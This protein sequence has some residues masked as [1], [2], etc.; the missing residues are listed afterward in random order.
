LRYRPFHTGLP[1]GCDQFGY[2]YQAEAIATGRLFVEHTSRPFFRPLLER[3]ASQ[4]PNVRDYAWMIAPHAYHYTARGDKIINQYPPGVAAVL[5]VVPWGQRKIAYPA[6][7]ALSMVALLALVW[8]ERGWALAGRGS[9]ILCLALIMELMHPFAFEY[10]GVGSV[11]P[12][13]ALL[14]AAGWLVRSRPAWSLALVSISIVFRIVN[15]W[16]LPPLAVAYVL[17]EVFAGS[18]L[19]AWR[20]LVLRSLGVAGICFVSGIG[21]MLLYQWLL[22]GNPFNWTYSAIDQKFAGWGRVLENVP[23]YFHAS[24][25][26]LLA[27]EAALVLTALLLRGRERLRWLL[28]AVCLAVWNYLFFLTHQIAMPYY[29]YASSLIILGLALSGMEALDGRTARAVATACTAGAVVA[30]AWSWPRPEPIAW[31]GAAERAAQYREAFGR[32]QVVWA[33]QSSGTVEYATGRA[34]FRFLWGS[35]AARLTALRWLHEHGY[36]QAVY[37][38]DTGMRAND[39][40][41]VLKGSGLPFTVQDHPRFHRLAWIE[42]DGR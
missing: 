11:A 38:D 9:A 31:D 32:A 16:L 42:A 37:L 6:L 23:F 17:R 15:A 24:Q 40:L 25:G 27:H 2:L 20:T 1:D 10:E 3:L 33:E 13:F 14:L 7:V 22:L 5:S 36:V 26:W 30:L 34:G 8:R 29:P 41:A 4:A 18:S 28:W 39:T 21:W 35:P 12:T 19:P